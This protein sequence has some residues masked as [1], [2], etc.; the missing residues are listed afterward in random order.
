MPED[1]QQTTP[2]SGGDMKPMLPKWDA[3]VNAHPNGSLLQTTS[4]GRL[5]A[6]FEWEWERVAV[7]TKTTPRA[8][9]M[10]LFQDLPLKLGTIAYIPRG[11]VVNWEDEAL[12]TELFRKMRKVAK[13]KH[14]WAIWVEPEAL[15]GDIAEQRLQSLGYENKGRTVQPPRTVFIDI[16]GDEPAILASMKSKTRYNIRLSERKGVTVRHGELSDLDMFYDLMTETGSRDEFGIHSKAYYQRVLELFLP[17]GTV[18]MLIA[19]AEGETLAALLVFA[20][21]E[22]AW[23]ITGASSDRQRNKMPT[24][25]LQ[26]EA[27]RWAKSRGCTCYDLWGVPDADEETLEAQFQEC[28]DGL[29]GVYRFKRGFGGRIVRYSGMW[30]KVLNPLYPLAMRFYK[31]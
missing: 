20:L 1:K 18:A 5:K 4:W 21:G 23:Y 7:G 16:D 13:R 2:H 9:A 27:I 26:W 3:W 28:D 17:T 24:Y 11:P 10:M 22:K 31:D 8:G 12:V 14:A 19:E 29:W 30:E 25:A 15:Q 6:S